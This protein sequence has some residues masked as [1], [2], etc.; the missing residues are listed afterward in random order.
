MNDHKEML[1]LILPKVKNNSQRL[2]EIKEESKEE[3]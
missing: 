2:G 3:N 1:N